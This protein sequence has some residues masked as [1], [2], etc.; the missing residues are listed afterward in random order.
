MTH[1]DRPSSDL[2]S[3]LAGG[4][5]EAGEAVA[6]RAAVD[7]DDALRTDYESLLATADLLADAP[8]VRAPRN[9]AAA[10]PPVE[11]VPWWSR[12]TPTLLATA[13]VALI[14]FALVDLQGSRA[15]DPDRAR[16][17]VPRIEMAAAAPV[18]QVQAAE[19]RAEVLI[20][21]GIAS[22]VTAPAPVAE[23]QAVEAA[24]EVVVE[25]EAEASPA[26]APAE[27]P[28]GA[29]QDVEAEVVIEPGIE[30][31][32]A[33]V[34]AAATEAMAESVE[35][36]DSKTGAEPEDALATQTVEAEGGAEAEVE[37]AVAAVAAAL[38]PAL[39]A[40]RGPPAGRPSPSPR[41][42]VSGLDPIIDPLWFGALTAGG[43]LLIGAG[44]AYTFRRR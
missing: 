4:E 31:A 33:A 38:P 13:A 43:L 35:A 32:V 44:F 28:V 9:Y 11:I 27:A 6:V 34:P 7:T 12:W 40:L 1:T 20:E 25:S 19:A 5:I 18:A 21:P 37:T 17:A 10:L 29:V 30:S 42:V 14:A 39:D 2:L 41:P 24:V 23:I 3:A 26:A 16:A 22:T 15:G 8:A 36:V